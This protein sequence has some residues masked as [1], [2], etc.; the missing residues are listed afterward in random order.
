MLKKAVTAVVC[1]CILNSSVF[2]EMTYFA[3]DGKLDTVAQIGKG[4]EVGTGTVDK[5]NSMG[6]K[7]FG[8]AWNIE[9][10][11]VMDVAKK[12][13]YEFTLSS[14]DGSALYINDKQVIINDG[15]HGNVKKSNSIRLKAGKH[16]VNL[17]Y[18]N[19]NGG[20]GL[21]ATVK[22]PNGKA[23]DLASVC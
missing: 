16:Q 1:I 11:G 5:I 23:P 8:D 10:S 14:D 15:L 22:A 19:N 20:H 6:D 17:L 7:K 12:G 13:K 2:A 4:K 3:H 9:F 18:F 21:S